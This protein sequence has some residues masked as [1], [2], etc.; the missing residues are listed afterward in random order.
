MK[1]EADYWVSGIGLLLIALL[2]LRTWLKDRYLKRKEI[3]DRTVD[4]VKFI[5]ERFKYL[6]KKTIK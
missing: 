5:E 6:N 3:H 4:Q 2:F 1:T